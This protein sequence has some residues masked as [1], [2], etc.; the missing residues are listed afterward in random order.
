MLS[1]RF[2]VEAALHTGLGPL[3]VLL[4]ATG[5]ALSSS[6]ASLWDGATRKH[7]ADRAGLGASGSMCTLFFS[8][9][10]ISLF[11]LYKFGGGGGSLTVAS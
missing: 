4:L 9:F 3:R 1:L 6:Y 7:G 5:A 10:F 2:G 8:F 11:L